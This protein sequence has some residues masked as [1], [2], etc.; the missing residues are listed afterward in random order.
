MIVYRCL[1]S[2]EILGM[3]QD[4]IYVSINT[5]KGENTFKYKED[6][7]YKHFFVYAEHAD[8]Y[9]KCN[10]Q[11]YPVIGQYVI[12]N[13]IIEQQGFGFY[14]GVTTMRNDGLYGYYA[15]LPEVI[16]NQ[17]DFKSE[18]LYK[19]ESELYSDFI[20]KKLDRLESN[21]SDLINLNSSDNENE[22][23]NEP[24]E[25]YF[26]PYEKGLHGRS[27][28]L[29]YS[30]ADVYY[31]MIYQLA[32]KNDMNLY[33][34]AQ[35]LKNIDLHYEIEEYFQKNAIFFEIQTKKYLKKKV[36]DKKYL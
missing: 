33:K 32:Q 11:K 7:K 29:D 5:N 23:Y 34:V 9:K 30:Y 24:M 16:I 20:T 35:I 19:L 2:N 26:L 17:S 10:R 12:P 15:P 4:N 21:F 13:E 14:G 22:K 1:T 8:Y 18:F 28:Y 25:E 31:E 27:G 36:A 3:I 6:K